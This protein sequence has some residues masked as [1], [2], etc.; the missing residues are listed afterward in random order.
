[1]VFHKVEV[2]PVNLQLLR[3]KL[4][5]LLLLL[6][7]LRFK[8]YF[9]LLL[10]ILL[11]HGFVQFDERF[12]GLPDQLSLFFDLIFLAVQ[13]ATCRHQAIVHAVDNT[14]ASGVCLHVR[15]FYMDRPA[16]AIANLSL[17]WDY[18]ASARDDRMTEKTDY[19]IVWELQV[20]HPI[21]A[22]EIRREE[23]I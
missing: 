3:F 13:M 15:D 2:R 14:F 12:S 18:E 4:Y 19:F 11:L 20:H 9:L 5:F 22:H 17:D 16:R 23:R 1:M 21:H 10:L 6:I 8:L 7:L